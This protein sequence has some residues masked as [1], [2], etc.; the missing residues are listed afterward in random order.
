ML[1]GGG[2]GVKWGWEWTLLSQAPHGN[3]WGKNGAWSL[4]SVRFGKV[5]STPLGTGHRFPVDLQRI[6]SQSD[7]KSFQV[8]LISISFSFSYPFFSLPPRFPNY[9]IHLFPPPPPPQ[10]L[11][12][13]KQNRSPRYV[14]VSWHWFF[15]SFRSEW[16]VLLSS[17][18]FRSILKS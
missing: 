12:K 4:G 8:P 10:P 9:V 6:Q 7:L 18:L 13:K 1:G 14:R 15:F 3:S 11:K 16:M 2:Q 17:Y 5:S